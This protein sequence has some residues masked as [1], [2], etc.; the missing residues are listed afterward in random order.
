ME[1]GVEKA[2]Q[3]KNKTTSANRDRRSLSATGSD[4]S[5]AHEEETDEE[6]AKSNLKTK[7]VTSL[8]DSI[9]DNYDMYIRPGLGGKKIWL[10]PLRPPP[11][12]PRQ[13]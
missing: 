4:D 2:Q 10:F 12:P 13:N 8:L 9:L 11:P 6:I 1:D 7:L 5:S 3:S